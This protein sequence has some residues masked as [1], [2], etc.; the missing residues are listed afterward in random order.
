MASISLVSL[1]VE[2]KLQFYLAG[3]RD[4]CDPCVVR[5]NVEAGDYILNELQDVTPV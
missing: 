3:D 5:S 1:P 2:V 4:D